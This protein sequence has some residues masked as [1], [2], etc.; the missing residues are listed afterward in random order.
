M[1]YIIEQNNIDGY[2]KI[3]SDNTL[4]GNIYKTFSTIGEQLVINITSLYNVDKIKS[5]ILDIDGT[6]HNHKYLEIEYR[7]SRDNNTFT[8]WLDLNNVTYNHPIINSYDLLYI[9]VRFTRKGDVSFGYI[10]LK[11]WEISCDLDRNLQDG[12]SIINIVDNGQNI[13]IRPPYIYK[14]FKLTDIEVISSPSLSGISLYWRYSQDYGRTVSKWEIFNKENVSSAKISPIRFFQVEYLIKSENITSNIK[15]YDINLIGDFQN[16]TLDSQKTNLM[17]I[18]DNCSCI[19]LGIENGQFVGQENVTNNTDNSGIISQTTSGISSG[20]NCGIGYLNA[21][22]DDQKQSLFQP[23]SIPNETNFLNQVSNDVTTIFGHE[24]SYFLTDPNS[25]GIDYTFHEYQLYNYVC[26]KTIKVSVDQN[27][28]PD[29]QITINQFDLSLFDTFE[30]HITKDEFKKAFGVDKRPSKQDFLWFCNLNRMF[31]VEHSQQFR[32]FNN[33]SIYYKVMLKK[34]SQKANVIGVNDTISDKVRELTRN[35]TIDELFGVYNE[36][37]KAAVANKEQTRV[38][39]KD[40]LRVD[41]NCIIEE[42]NVMNGNDM[43][44]KN[45]YN[46]STVGFGEEAISYRNMKNIYEKSDNLSFFC[47]FKIEN[48][49]NSENYNLFTYYDGVNSNGIK[50]NI[51]NDNFN[52]LINNTIYSM[53]VSNILDFIDTVDLFENR[54]LCYLVN[55]EQRNNKIYQY[56][57]QRDDESYSNKISLIIKN[58]LPFNSD[59]IVIDNSVKSSILG[60][61]MYISNLRLFNDIIDEKVHSKT[62]VTYLVRD[63]AKYLI[64]AD[65]CNKKIILPSLPLSNGMDSQT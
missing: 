65:N 58:E 52:V 27:N 61:D 30:I 49:I 35:S 16:V 46:L 38:L 1:S 60:S 51:T 10:D 48:Y 4:S 41:I 9:D 28:F 39:T 34:Y 3:K 31:Q 29:N 17:G 7:I 24:V 56:L 18:R 20:S 14:V 54:W 57:Y 23:Y 22:T 33:S 64:F 43:I 19:L 12:E 47:W 59:V 2:L 15:I 40:T 11:K 36:Q 63:D 44:I 8:D 50:I 13:V 42:D 37:D 53:D 6:I 25:N 32:N 26:E 62:L 21:L 45:V 55:I 5:L